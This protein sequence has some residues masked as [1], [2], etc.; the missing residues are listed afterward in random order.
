MTTKEEV[1]LV[2]DELDELI[3]VPEP[4]NQEGYNKFRRW[5]IHNK[6]IISQAMLVMEAVLDEDWQ[7]IATAPRDGTTILCCWVAENSKTREMDFNDCEV[8]SYFPDWHGE[9]KGG[10]VL[11]GDFNLKFEPDGF[12][13]TPPKSF[14]IPTHWKPLHSKAAEIARG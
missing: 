8:L 3:F 9:G 14:E 6:E 4:I 1:Q 12:H 11:A 13:E 5:Q 7:D 10:W 2:I